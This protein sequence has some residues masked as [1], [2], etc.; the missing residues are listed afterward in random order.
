MGLS[1]CPRAPL[2]RGSASSSH[3]STS[4]MRASGRTGSLPPKR[5]AGAT[6]DSSRFA[7]V[8]G[9]TALSFGSTYQTLFHRPV[10][11]LRPAPPLRTRPLATTTSGNFASRLA[12]MLNSG[13]RSRYACSRPHSVRV[14]RARKHYENGVGVRCLWMSPLASGSWIGELR[15]IALQT[16]G[17]SGVK[18]SYVC[19]LAVDGANRFAQYDRIGYRA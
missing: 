19:D 11:R 16:L 17:R 10:L 5:I 2:P 18:L 4:P 12:R 3:A 6:G 1:T 9:G 7:A 13:E 14:T 15:Q 8:P